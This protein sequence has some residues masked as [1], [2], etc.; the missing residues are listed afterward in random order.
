[1]YGKDVLASNRRVM[2][3]KT[4]DREKDESEENLLIQPDWRRET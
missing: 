2:D 4:G 3:D 1:M